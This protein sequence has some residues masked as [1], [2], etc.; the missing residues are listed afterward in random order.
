MALLGGVGGGNFASSMSNISAPSFRSVCRAPALGL[1]AGLGNFGVTAMQV[2]HTAGDDRR[3]LGGSFGG[4]SMTLVKDSGWILGKITAGTPTLDPERWLCLGC[5]RCCRCRCSFFGMNNL[6]TAVRRHTVA[7]SRPLFLKIH[8]ALH[9]VPL[10][11]SARRD[12]ISTCQT[13]RFGPAQYVDR[14]AADRGQRC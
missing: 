12:C 8:V 5:C 6:L 9:P 11:R 1:N 3:P 14:H 2:R 10:C 7:R 4:G 13:Y